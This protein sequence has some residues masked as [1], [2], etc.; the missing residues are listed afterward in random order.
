MHLLPIAHL[1]SNAPAT[2]AQHPPR[3]LLQ[4]EISHGKKC[5]EKSC[6]PHLG[7]KLLGLVAGMEGS[8][9]VSSMPLAWTSQGR[10]WGWQMYCHAGCSYRKLHQKHGVISSFYLSVQKK[11]RKWCV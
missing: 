9:L 11:Q 2:R 5:K 8:S 3:C 7:G 4:A 6:F 1:G 10:F